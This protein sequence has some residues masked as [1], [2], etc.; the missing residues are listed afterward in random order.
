MY[1]MKRSHEIF[2]LTVALGIPD[3]Y[4]GFYVRSVAFPGP[5]VCIFIKFKGEYQA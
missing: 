5:G 3:M 4:P 1:Q 2:G